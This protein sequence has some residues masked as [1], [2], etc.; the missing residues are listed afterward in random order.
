MSYKRSAIVFL[1]FLVQ[2]KLAISSVLKCWK[3]SVSS[4]IQGCFIVSKVISEI[5]LAYSMINIQSHLWIWWVNEAWLWRSWSKWK[6]GSLGETRLNIFAVSN[7][8]FSLCLV[9]W[10]D[11]TEKL[12]MPMAN[13]PLNSRRYSK[14]N[15]T[16]YFNK[17][18]S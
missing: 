7:L 1:W 18:A 16:V 12:V 14:K 2:F 17:I 5:V 13:N 8:L 6:C 11:S 9:K 4:E 10:M 3:N 15:W